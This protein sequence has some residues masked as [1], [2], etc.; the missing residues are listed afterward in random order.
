MGS[1]A[2]L[3][4]IVGLPG[5]GKTTR[6]REL[7]KAHRALRFTPDEWMIPLF[8]GPEAGK[9]DLL[10]GLLIS[11]GLDALVVGTN[12]VLDFGFW[13]LDERSALRWL[14]TSVGAAV[15]VVYVPVDEATQRQRVGERFFARPE[16]TFPMS[17]SDLARWRA[18]FEEPTAGE[19]AGAPVPDRPADASSWADWARL[20]WP[21]SGLVRHGILNR[22]FLARLASSAWITV[23]VWSA[24][25][26]MSWS[27]TPSMAAACRLLPYTVPVLIIARSRRQSRPS[28]PVWATGGSTRICR[29]WA[30]RRPT[31]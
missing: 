8:G 29:G 15:E 16:Q 6:A 18:Q 1:S 21:S 19:L 23:S 14:G 4:L 17:D 28:S 9:R 25:S 30:A 11:A 3:F 24:G 20:R 13:G 7:G 26:A 12:V 5:A 2:T 22:L 27:I 10:E 31:A